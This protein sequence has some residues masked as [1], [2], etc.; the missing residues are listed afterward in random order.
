MFKKSTSAKL[1]RSIKGAAMPGSEASGWPGGVIETIASVSSGG[2]CSAS[3][4][5][6]ANTWRG[7]GAGGGR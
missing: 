1:R 7:D 6:S 2:S 5:G 4:R 3:A